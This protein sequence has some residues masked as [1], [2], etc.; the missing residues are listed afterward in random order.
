MSEEESL[1]RPEC[2]ATDADPRV[3]ALL[4]GAMVA[5]V[6]VCL[7]SGLLIV[8]R[9]EPAATLPQ[10]NEGLFQHGPE[11]RTDIEAAWTSLDPTAAPVPDGY[12]WID[13]RA[14]IV[15]VP[16]DRAIDLV[17]AEQARNPAKGHSP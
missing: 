8:G 10:N 12:G 5:I 17:C 1:P 14:G 11:E 16:I 13:R 4:A 9:P 6:A 2:E 15:R 3:P 7:L